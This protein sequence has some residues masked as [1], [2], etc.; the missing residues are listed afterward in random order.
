MLCALKVTGPRPV[1]PDLLPGGGAAS[2][3]VL[4]S[5]CQCARRHMPTPGGPERATGRPQ[6]VLNRLH[7]QLAPGSSQRTAALTGSPFAFPVIP[8][9][10]S[11]PALAREGPPHLSQAENLEARRRRQRGQAA[12]P[13]P[14][15]MP[16]PA[17]GHGCPGE[18][19]G[20]VRAQPSPTCLL[21]PPRTESPRSR[22]QPGP[23]LGPFQRKSPSHQLSAPCSLVTCVRFFG[24]A[25][26]R[27]PPAV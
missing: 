2:P 16:W 4:G 18:A 11:G 13:C 25:S 20:R 10:P 9:S 1:Q 21:C 23:L 12:S 24:A 17:H 3:Q 5:A 14:S 6:A 19:V 15:S 7:T 26:P 27:A 22:S 8:R